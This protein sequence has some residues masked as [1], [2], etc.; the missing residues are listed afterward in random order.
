MTKKAD[1]DWNHIQT[2]ITRRVTRANDAFASLR[3][4]RPELARFAAPG[5]LTAELQAP[6]VEAAGRDGLYRALLG[7]MRDREEVHATLARDLL[8]LG[9]WPVLSEIYQHARPVHAD[10]AHAAA[11]VSLAF[12][13]VIVG[14]V[15][16]PTEPA[17]DTIARE[18]ASE[19][20]QIQREEQKW[21]RAHKVDRAA[22]HKAMQD[23]I[24][25]PPR[26]VEAVR[27]ELNEAI[28]YDGELLFLYV[29]LDES[30]PEIAQREGI[31]AR[32]VRRRI[33]RARK[34]LRASRR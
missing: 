24:V 7:A 10:G 19:L 16:V 13:E 28:G 9:I 8:W 26:D 4:A 29:V 15:L 32:T 18:T 6:E 5:E 12:S 23:M 34:R 22:V 11:D 33:D 27:A 14:I 20:K 25:E 31:S 1:Q 2:A 3:R 21:T 17:I 30:M